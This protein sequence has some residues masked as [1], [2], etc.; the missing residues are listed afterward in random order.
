MAAHLKVHSLPTFSHDEDPD[1]YLSEASIA[2]VRAFEIRTRH[3]IESRKK[4]LRSMVGEQ[5]VDLIAAADT[6]IGMDKKTT[7]IKENLARMRKAC[8]EKTIKN[9]AALIPS[10][11]TDLPHDEKRLHQYTL[12]ALIKALADVPKQ[13]WHALE[14]HQY[15]LAGSLYTLAEQVHAFL[16]SEDAFAIDVDIAFPVIQRQWDAISFFRSQIIQKAIHHLRALTTNSSEVAKVLMTLIL[17]DGMNMES[18][19]QILLDRRGQLIKE[20]VQASLQNDHQQKLSRQLGDLAMAIKMTVLHVDQ[21]FLSSVSSAPAGTTLLAWYANQMKT[22]FMIPQP[23]GSAS[24]NSSNHALANAQFETSAT[25]WVSVLTRMF[26]PT[27]NAHLLIRHLPDAI[28]HFTPTTHPGPALTKAIVSPLITQWLLEIKEELD[29]HLPDILQPL[30]TQHALLQVRSLLSDYL[31][32]DND[33]PWRQACQHILQPDYSIYNDLFRASF[34]T[35]ARI[36]VDERLDNL[37]KQPMEKVWPAIVNR[38]GNAL[39]KGFQLAPSIW[40]SASDH[41]QT[42]LPLPGLSSSIEI[43]TFKKSLQQISTQRTFLL[44]KLLQAFDDALAEVRSDT[45]SHLQ[46]VHDTRIPSE[47]ISSII[48]YLQEQCQVATERY[49]QGLESLLEKWKL[50]DNREDANTLSIWVGRLAKLI[51]EQSQQ[52]ACTLTFRGSQ[53]DLLELKSDVGK[54]PRFVALQR[55]FDATYENAHRLWID[56]MCE[57]FEQQFMH[58]L[59]SVAWND[60]CPA[61][62][63]WEHVDQGVMLPTVASFAIEEITFALCK[64]IQRYHCSRLDK[65]NMHVTIRSQHLCHMTNALFPFF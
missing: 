51:G 64:D 18:A 49:I 41:K 55:R 12:A 22:A 2:E 19:L 4:E 26:S 34:N 59:S 29:I 27:V 35:H 63:V 15:L 40:P 43:S 61:I 25:T 3:N 16:E 5:Y 48:G 31:Y 53:T 17:L 30:S 50:W 58:A 36:I 62:A 10:S 46:H 14:S 42:S 45:A 52:L 57:R 38:D 1:T 33:A 24:N 56:W 39:K 13:I 23:T 44:D 37:S 11:G 20:L 6:I 28:Q 32:Q 47:D 54:D 7:A 9:V 8:D 60:A 21:I 65:V